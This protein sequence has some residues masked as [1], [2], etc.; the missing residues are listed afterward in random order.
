MSTDR[1]WRRLGEL[2]D[3]AAPLA[4][5]ERAAFITG[6]NE[7]DVSLR[8]ELEAMLLADSTGGILD[9]RVLDLAAGIGD[10]GTASSLIGAICGNWRIV[11]FLGRG[12]MGAVY[13]AERADGA[14]QQQ[15]ALKLIRLGIDSPEVRQRFLRE[16]QILAQLKHPHI[17]A[18]LDGGLTD[19]GQPY[20][21]MELVEGK[22]ID[23]WC[24]EQRLPV[25]ERLRLF[26]EVLDAVQHAHA[27]MVVHRD[28]KPSNILIDAQGRAKL[29]DFGIAKLL[30]ENTGTKT[31]DRPVTPGYAAPEQLRGEPISVSTD[32]YALGVVLYQLLSGAHPFG[33][34]AST[35]IQQQLQALDGECT[36]I[37]RAAAR[38]TPDVVAA[39]SLSQPALLRALRGDLAAIVEICLAKE[40]QRRYASTEALAA[41][42]R[43]CLAGEPV[44]VRAGSRRYRAAKFVRRH[45]GILVMLAII[46]LAFAGGL[47]V[48]VWQ[49]RQASGVTRS[50]AV[51]PFVDRSTNK[52]QDYFSD[53]ISEELLTTLAKVDG[54]RVAARTSSFAFKNATLDVRQIGGKLHVGSVLEGSVRRNGQR[55]HVT[56][57][58]IEVATG[59]ELWSETY[60]RDFDDLLAVQ[61]TIASAI[62]DALKIKLAVAL[63]KRKAIDPEAYD[64]YLQG[65]FFSNKSTEEGL[66]HSLDLFERSLNKDPDNA[67]AWSG[68]A[69]DWNWL[70][71]AYVRPL[72][73][74]PQS[75]AAALKAL[76]L[77]QD[78]A[79]AHAYL[80]DAMRVLDRDLIGAEREMRRA[81]QLNPNSSEALLFLALLRSTNGDPVEGTA[82]IQQALKVDPLSPIISNFAAMIYLCTGRYDDAIAQ[83]EQTQRLDESYLYLSPFL[84]DTYREQGRFAEA[85]T[86]F[87]KAEQATR[88]PQAG[89]A[90]TYARMGRTADARRILAELE[91]KAAKSYVSGD[92]IA[93]IYVEL[94]DN[95]RAFDWLQRAFDEHAAPLHGIGIAPRFRPLHKDPR[96]AKLLVKLGLDAQRILVTD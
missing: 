27:A 81:L 6:L 55:L 85:V 13:R 48:A 28:L 15:A 86:V 11:D 87:R 75:K 35:P 16:R 29:L 68:I 24:D 31:R 34:T 84:A 89:L 5:P 43:R 67:N 4:A 91:D 18:L 95:D 3:Q 33:L 69:K 19:S 51:L 21:A 42:L 20:F 72:D 17:A 26:L 40:P 54:L 71:D 7:D 9:R 52:D 22:A 61:D 41:D 92:D 73:A 50:I 76:A 64:L 8:A 2:F 96:F 74:F 82:L 37:T 14:Y 94:G 39:R 23:R 45:R 10:A 88:Q 93:A 77:D 79:A 25:G 78:N 49:S 58:L 30:E 57:E 32:I 62:I 90:I 66:R 46:V 44:S 65:V 36:P 47:G 59:Y 63:P 83:A 56:A 60:E 38:A 70:S 53:G 12:G 80:G 1:R